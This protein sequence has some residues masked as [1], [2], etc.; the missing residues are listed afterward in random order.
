MVSRWKKKEKEKSTRG[1]TA[2]KFLGNG[3]LRRQQQ[4]SGG[5]SSLLF[6]RVSV[7]AALV[8]SLARLL[9]ALSSLSL[10]FSVRLGCRVFSEFGI[11]A[12]LVR[13]NN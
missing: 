13:S 10:S 12:A 3:T 6:S 8:S 1:V 4:R 9:R 2:G 7:V 11:I 5:L